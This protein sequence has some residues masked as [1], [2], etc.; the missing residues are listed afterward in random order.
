LIFSRL[1]SEFYNPDSV[2][3]EKFPG[4]SSIL[5]VKKRRTIPP[6]L[7]Y[8][9]SLAGFNPVYSILII[10]IQIFGKATRAILEMSQQ[11][12]DLFYPYIG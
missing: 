12:Q 3:F 5:E 1:L 9:L 2:N 4:Q 6:F 8:S 11:R 10:D 7:F